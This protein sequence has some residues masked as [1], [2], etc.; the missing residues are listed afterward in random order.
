MT[1]VIVTEPLDD[2]PPVQ[3]TVNVT[4]CPGFAVVDCGLI[5]HEV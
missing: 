3:L 5:E 2:D 4:V 1:R